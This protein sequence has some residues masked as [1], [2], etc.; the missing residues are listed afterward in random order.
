MLN[1]NYLLYIKKID[2]HKPF[3]FNSVNTSVRK[4]NKNNKN[5]EYIGNRR[6]NRY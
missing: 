1:I 3:T 2:K 5:N 4:Y 6:H